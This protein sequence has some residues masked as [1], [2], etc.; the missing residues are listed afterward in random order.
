MV[1]CGA[2]LVCLTGLFKCLQFGGPLD[3][4]KAQQLQAPEALAGS[5]TQQ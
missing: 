5:H 3:I 2:V 1:L 4:P